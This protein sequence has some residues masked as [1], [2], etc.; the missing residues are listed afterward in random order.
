MF[1]NFFQKQ[2]SPAL[3][4]SRRESQPCTVGSCIVWLSSSGFRVTRHG[5]RY[6]LR[7]TKN[8]D[9]EQAS[10]LLLAAAGETFQMLSTIRNQPYLGACYCT[11]ENV[12]RDFPYLCFG[13]RTQCNPQS[14]VGH[15]RLRYVPFAKW[16]SGWA[17]MCFSYLRG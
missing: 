17:W 12:S 3:A 14:T 5:M 8:A 2:C 7:T 1:T 15:V 11:V 6:D 13:F 4:A 9:Q 10:R 16:T